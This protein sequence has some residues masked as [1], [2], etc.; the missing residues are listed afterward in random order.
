MVTPLVDRDVLDAGGLVR[1]IEHI[2]A[3][4]VQGL[5]ILGTTGEGPSLSHRLRHELVERTCRE[6]AGRVPVLV[7]ITDTAF[8]ESVRL[9]RKAADCGAAAVVLAPPYYFPAGQPELIEYLQHMVPELPLPLLLYNMPSHT[10]L[11]FEPETVLAAAA[12]PGI[13]GL[14]DSSADLAYF[15]R[16]LALLEGRREFTLLVGPEMLLAQCVTLGAHGGVCGGANL[17]PRLY[18]A[19]YQAA[20]AGDA[21]A[22]R[23]LHEVAAAVQSKIYGVGHHPSSYLKGLKCALACLGLCADFMAEPFHRFR[24]PERRIIREHLDEL[25]QRMSAA[26]IGPPA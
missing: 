9:A 7:G 3:G 13:V 14:K 22:V 23:R 2:L 19:L 12:M 8:V 21:E 18:V 1:L 5:F 26:G 15:R 17:F 25:S 11:V 6:V 20:A 16:L 4:G 10:K 24:D